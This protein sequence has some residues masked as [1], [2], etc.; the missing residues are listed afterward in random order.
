VGALAALGGTRREA[1]WQAEALG[2]SGTLFAQATVTSPSPLPEMTPDE[3][4]IADFRGTNVTTGP[5]PISFLRNILKGQG[6]LSAAELQH[7]RD[8]ETVRTAGLVVVRQR[9]GTAKGFVFITLEDETG[10]ANAIATPTIFAQWRP[11]IL[12]HATLGIEGTVQNRDGVVM[13]VAKRFFTVEKP[14]TT[15][16]SGVNVSHDFR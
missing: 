16:T 12:G 13:L 3:E 10:F 14:A 7:L 11:L 9:P 6:V 5:H 2:R 15:Y 8:G 1:L 4:M